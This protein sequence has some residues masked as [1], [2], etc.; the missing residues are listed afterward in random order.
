MGDWSLM[1]IN[2]PPAARVDGVFFRFRYKPHVNAIGAVTSNNFY[3]DRLNISNF[4]TGANTLINDDRKI[5]VA[6]NP[7]SGSS[8][9]IIKGDIGADANIVVTDITGKLVYKT[10]K[11]INSEYVTIEIPS[12]SLT[13]KGMYMVQV[14]TNNQSHTEKLVVY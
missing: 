10:T 12:E 11:K 1:S 4:P 2:V 7:T 6:P 9:I 3:M 14:V 5:V 8:T 13:A